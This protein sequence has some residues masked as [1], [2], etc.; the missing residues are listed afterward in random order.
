MLIYIISIWQKKEKFN[1]TKYANE[2]KRQNYKRLSVL[3]PL[4]ESELLT[5]IESNAPVS[6][7]FLELA[8][9][10]F[11]KKQKSEQNNKE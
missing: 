9:A 7:Y 1:P 4:K 3:V 8:K 11:I 5:Y 2:F 6:S 10:D